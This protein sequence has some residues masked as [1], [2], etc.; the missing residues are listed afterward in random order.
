[1][2]YIKLISYVN[3]TQTRL[4]RN[5]SLKIRQLWNG[6][7][8]RYQSLWTSSAIT[9]DESWVDEPITTVIHLKLHSF[10]TSSR[11]LWVTWLP[12]FPFFP[13]VLV[14]RLKI[15]KALFFSNMCWTP[16]E[17]G[18][19]DSIQKACS[20]PLLWTV[21]MS[22]SL[23]DLIIFAFSFCSSKSSFYWC[24]VKFSAVHLMVLVCL[25]KHKW[26][27]WTHL[28][29]I[30]EK[31]T[32]THANL[33]MHDDRLLFTKN[34]KL[35]WQC[36][37]QRREQDLDVIWWR[38]RRCPPLH[39]LSEHAHKHAQAPAGRM[40][41]VTQG[42]HLTRRTPHHDVRP[43]FKGVRDECRCKDRLNMWP[44]TQAR[45]LNHTLFS[46]GFTMGILHV[47]ER[48]REECWWFIYL[49]LIPHGFF[50]HLQSPLNI[51]PFL[52]AKAPGMYVN[53]Y[54]SSWTKNRPCWKKSS[55]WFHLWIICPLLL[56]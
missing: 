21:F 36:E 39:P 45:P 49:F 8:G 38:W 14:F 24:Q 52:S 34:T 43:L 56:I 20:Y 53:T 17:N 35:L 48:V 28:S 12:F 47:C 6:C 11:Q 46:C 26:A 55:S 16:E 4:L 18:T 1:M 54:S 5:Y 41:L 37:T 42:L 13:F 33:Y 2:C 15:M 7:F 25:A 32:V 29:D 44:L 9:T 22:Q 51:L 27:L 3:A 30:W 31:S 40:V 23:N 19:C 10:F 50:F